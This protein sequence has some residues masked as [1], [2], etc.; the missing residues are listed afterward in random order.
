M[1]TLDTLKEYAPD[2]NISGVI[3]IGAWLIIIT[4][5]LLLF[6][7]G[8]FFFIR[9]LKFNRKIIILEDVEGSDSLEPIGKDKAMLVKIAKSGMEVLYLKKRKTYKGAY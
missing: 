2:F 3:S 8:L 4:I 1:A 7:V 5:F 9:A 6:G